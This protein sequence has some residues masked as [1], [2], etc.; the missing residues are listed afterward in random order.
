[1]GHAAGFVNGAE[2]L[3]GAAALARHGANTA[4]VSG[5]ETLSYAGLSSRVVTAAAAYA[6]LGVRPGDRV[7]ILLRDTPDFPVAWLGAMWAGAIPI[8]LNNKLAQTELQ[9]VA[10]DSAACLLVSE[11]SLARELGVRAVDAAELRRAELP[12]QPHPATPDDAAFWLYS[13]GTTG[14]PK[15]IVH[16]HRAVLAAGQAQREVL[17]LGAGDRVLATSKL[18]FA[19]ALEN[20][21]LGPLSLGAAAILNPDW[22]SVEGI[23]GL[24]ERHKPTAFF[25]V[26]SFYRQLL[27][28]PPARIAAFRSARRFAAAGERL[29]AQVVASW[30]AATDGE[31]LSI[32]GMSETFCV[33]MVTRPGTSDGS[34][35]GQPLQGIEA[36]LDG[37]GDEPGVLWLRHPAL[38][39]AYANRPEQTREQFRD[40][41]F[42]TNDMFTRDAAGNYAHQGRADELIKVAGQ[43]VRPSEIEELVLAQPAIADAACVAM[44]DADGFERL[45]LFV[46]ARDDTDAALNAAGS[47]CESLPSR[48]QR[49]KWIRAVAELP[50]TATGK[51]QRFR[52]RELLEQELGRNV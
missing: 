30:R 40:G 28:Q 23:C 9:H 5:D 26:P 32:Y 42:C 46:A 22:A 15:G 19:Y 24:V 51:V 10:Q 35:T 49:P 16:A 12:V 34:H 52:L 2:Y 31:I 39:I 4:L 36:R 6:R 8:G 18:F 14:R 25:S 17:G 47:A 13:S 7:L 44:Q 37:T 33:S 48:H 29:P 20:G 21:L 43:W 1:V 45:A 3:L 38:A 11:P 50:R 41:W 27:A